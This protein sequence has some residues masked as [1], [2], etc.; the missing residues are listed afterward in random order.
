MNSKTGYE[1]L[2]TLKPIAD[3]VWISDGGWIRFY[4]LPFPTR[5]TIVRLPGD[6][7]WVHSPIALEGRLLEEVSEIGD[8]GYLIAPNWI[9]YAWINDW[10]VHFPD[11]QTWGCPGVVER[12]KSR[13][14]ALRIDQEL[15]GTAPSD[16]SDHIDQFQAR[17]K[18][19]Q[20]V[21]FFHGATRTLILTDLIENFERQYLPWWM[22][23]LVKLGH[24]CAPDG[25]MPRDIAASFRRDPDHLHK[26]IDTMIRWDPLRIV[27]SHGRWFE[28]NGRS[29]LL[30][31]FRDDLDG[32]RA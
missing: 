29:E 14:R 13:G 24:V 21:I 3:E 16:W 26:L 6:V 20:E 19:H 2:Y 27:I 31:V 30:R 12:A 22:R 9:H 4:G 28:E 17:S 5:M 15:G 25:R 1:P 10:Q 23:P 7:L 32:R 11:A 8:V 18:L